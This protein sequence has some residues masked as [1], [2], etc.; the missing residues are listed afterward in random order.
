[1]KIP[2]CYQ[3]HLPH[4]DKQGFPTQEHAQ[5][6]RGSQLMTVN[7]KKSTLN[8]NTSKLIKW[9]TTLLSLPRWTESSQHPCQDY[10]YKHHALKQQD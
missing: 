6:Y 10:D 4:K 5:Q 3:L 2:E 7:K 8:V 1:M 9:E